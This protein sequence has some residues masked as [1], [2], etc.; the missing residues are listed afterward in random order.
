M[1]DNVRWFEKSDLDREAINNILPCNIAVDI[2]T[3]IRPHDFVDSVVCICC[4]PY[5]EYVEILKNK[6]E[7]K[8]DKIYV[9]KQQTWAEALD[10][11][12]D[13]SIDT[14]FLIDVIEHLSK[15]EGM[16][17]LRRTEGIARKQIVLFTPL[18]FV[19]QHTLEGGKDAWGLNGAEWQEHKSGWLP[20][21]FDDSWEVYACRHYH[22]RNNIN[23]KL[24]EAFGAFWAIKT[25]SSDVEPNCNEI[26]E[27][28]F[29]AIM[30]NMT[31]LN[32]YKSKCE[33]LIIEN[34]AINNQCVAIINEINSLM[35]ENE[36]LRS[37]LDRCLSQN[38]VM[39][40]ALT[41][42]KSA[43]KILE[44]TKSVRLARF[45]KRKLNL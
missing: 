30:A 6:V 19:A 4:E 32:D 33:K 45:I 10:C 18:G 20:E 24:D 39:Q 38:M 28:T 29:Q 41:E 36:L 44:N 15:D 21:D 16:M 31:K 40:N 14:I 9:V 11:L 22:D 34:E 7:E 37:E 8:T 25:F 5:A 27:N 13:K 17:L 1:P 35:M 23:E 43:Y 42:S 3:G 2:G 12:A 26:N